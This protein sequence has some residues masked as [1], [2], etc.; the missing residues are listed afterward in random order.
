[1]QWSTP[2]VKYI[3]NL[4]ECC[5]PSPGILHRHRMQCQLH[6]CMHDLPMHLS[7][8]ANHVPAL[9]ESARGLMAWRAALDRG[10]LPDALV[11]QQLIEAGEEPFVAGCTVDQLRWPEEPLN[12]MLVR[13]V[14]ST[15]HCLTPSPEPRF[16]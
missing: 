11:L 1:M 8:G 4:L 10:L 14:H 9:Q 12:T 13:W 15:A 7:H 2:H 16:R 6:I 3:R 5:T